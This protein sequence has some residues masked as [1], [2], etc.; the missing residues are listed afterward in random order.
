MDA[1][2]VL[3]TGGLILAIPAGGITYFFTYRFFENIQKRRQRKK[4]QLSGHG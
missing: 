2:L 4:R 3:L 1:A